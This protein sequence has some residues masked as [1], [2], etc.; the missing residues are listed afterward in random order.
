MAE[1]TEVSQ[2]GISKLPQPIIHHILSFLEPKEE[3]K[4]SLLSKAWLSRWNTRPI[5]HF[6]YSHDWGS[7]Y[8]TDIQV[9]KTIHEN[10]MNCIDTTLLR[11]HH[12]KNGIDTLNLRLYNFPFVSPDD[13]DRWLQIAVENGVK[14]L[15]IRIYNYYVLPQTVFEA[16]SLLELSLSKCRLHH[17][18]IQIIRCRGLANIKATK[19]QKLK[20]FSV[21]LEEISG[22]VEVE[23]PS[24]EDFNYDLKL[25]QTS[26]FSKLKNLL[27]MLNQSEISLGIK[28]SSNLVGMIVDEMLMENG[29]IPLPEVEELAISFDRTDGLDI[30]Y[31][32]V[33]NI[34]FACRPKTIVL[35]LG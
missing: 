32:V 12:Q 28:F 6:I 4:T 17:H 3:A 1:T 9:I 2:D 33:D 25:L 16:K 14:R 27:M 13:A 18:L 7:S 21:T 5:L 34:L 23:A 11:Y 24:L 35:N 10:F 22:S 20:R 26:Y 29:I 15:S 8:D 19:L 31:L 30:V